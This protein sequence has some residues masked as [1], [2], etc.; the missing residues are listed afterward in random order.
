MNNY[1]VL[2]KLKHEN[3]SDKGNKEVHCQTIEANTFSEVEL[4]VKIKWAKVNCDAE[5]IQITI[6]A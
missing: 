5:I 6:G 1:I 3:N 4:I 2:T